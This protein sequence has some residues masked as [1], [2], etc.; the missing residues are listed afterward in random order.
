MLAI[1]GPPA[2]SQQEVLHIDSPTTS[3]HSWNLYI[4]DT[5][6]GYL[7]TSQKSADMRLPVCELN[8]TRLHPLGTCILPKCQL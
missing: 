3:T 2:A 8:V 7:F 4:R 5:P 6:E 1:T